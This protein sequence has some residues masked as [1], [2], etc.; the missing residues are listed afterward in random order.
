MLRQ[1]DQLKEQNEALRVEKESWKKEKELMM[2][3]NHELAESNAKM[4]DQ[5]HTAKQ[6]ALKVSS[7]FQDKEDQAKGTQNA[8]MPGETSH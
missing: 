3:E 7:S 8:L 4:V 5:V 6:D 2:K 1:I